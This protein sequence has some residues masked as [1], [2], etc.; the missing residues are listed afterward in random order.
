MK[1]R[2]AMNEIDGPGAKSVLMK[3]IYRDA[4]ISISS[5]P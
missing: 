1:C 5:S 2:A 4:H 3:K